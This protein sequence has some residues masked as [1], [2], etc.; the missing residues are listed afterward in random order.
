VAQSK[1][2][3]SGTEIAQRIKDI[4]EAIKSPEHADDIIELRKVF[5]KNVP[6]FFRSYFAAY[7]LKQSLSSG[8]K[9]GQRDQ[10]RNRNQGKDS[11]RDQP[12]RD[13][14]KTQRDPVAQGGKPQREREPLTDDEQRKR[15]ERKNE[16]T[17]P[18]P[19][20][21]ESATL[22]VS[23]GRKRHFY[24]R[25]L[26]ELFA[27][28]G[29][30]RESIGEIRLFDNYTFVQ[31]L[32]EDAQAAVSSLDGALFKGRKLTVNFARKKDESEEPAPRRE[33]SNA[34]AYSE[35][36]SD[37]DSAADIESDSEDRPEYDEE[38]ADALADESDEDL[39]AESD[40]YDDGQALSDGE[41]IDSEGD[42][43]D[44]K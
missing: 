20:G 10:G 17:P 28:A 29:I 12:K 2:I 22:F 25:H 32:A 42:E 13:E 26:L 40:G 3:P 18:L 44:P 9:G 31:I 34:D 23:A 30:P 35:S 21:V 41:G 27:G 19:E 38:A 1:N 39:A 15:E 33:S 4:L 37:S 16:R 36:E 7:L 43:A 11:Q 24:P 8:A 14:R 5:R 6:F